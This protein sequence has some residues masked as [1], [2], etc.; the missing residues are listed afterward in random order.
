MK[1]PIDKPAVDRRQFTFGV[2]AAGALAAPRPAPA[3]TNIAIPTAC[4]T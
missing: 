3:A 1:G 4:R 2:I